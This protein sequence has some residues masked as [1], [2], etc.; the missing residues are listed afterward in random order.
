MGVAVDDFL[1][2]LDDLPA[3][4]PWGDLKIDNEM[5]DDIAFEKRFSRVIT[6]CLMSNGEYERI[7]PPSPRPRPKRPSGSKIRVELA[8]CKSCRAP[9]WCDTWT[10]RTFRTDIDGSI[11]QKHAC[12]V[13]GKEATR[14]LRPR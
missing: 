9:R 10:I 5:L 11:Q 14:R 8:Y 1:N 2:H 7:K 4:L 12:H 3:G 13:C 6:P